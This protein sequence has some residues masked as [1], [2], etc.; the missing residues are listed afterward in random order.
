MA[1]IDDKYRKWIIAGFS[2]FLMV[3]FTLPGWFGGRLKNREDHSRITVYGK[4]KVYDSEIEDAK[5][6]VQFI[7]SIPYGI[8]L[9]QGMPQMSLGMSLFMGDPGQYQTY[10]DLYLALRVAQKGMSDLLAAPEVFALLKREAVHQGIRP[11]SDRV[12]SILHNQIPAE[13]IDEPRKLQDYRQKITA[14]V[15]VETLAQQS[16]G[17]VKV[18][19]PEIESSLA[20]QLQTLKIGVV[21]IDAKEYLSKVDAPTDE[22]VRAMFA[23]YGSRPTDDS[24]YR[25]NPFNF[26]YL[27]GDRVQFE[28]ITLPR[29]SL[30]RTAR[31]SKSEYDWEVEAQKYYFQNQKSFETDEIPSTQPASTQPTYKPFT[32][33][34]QSILDRLTDAKADQLAKMAQGKL[35]ATM[36]ADSRVYADAVSKKAP[37]P[38]SSLGPVYNTR[39]YLNALAAKVEA[40]FG[41]HAAVVSFTDRFLDSD[42]LARTDSIGRATIESANGREMTFAAY[43]LRYAKPFFETSGG[44]RDPGA[45]ALE[46]FQPTPAFTVPGPTG[47]VYV[48][49]V[50]DAKAS[51]VP[52]LAE[53]EAAVKKDAVTQGAQDLAVAAAEALSAEQPGTPLPTLGAAKGKK[54]LTLPALRRNT[55]LPLDFQLSPA[56]KSA[57]ITGCFNLLRIDP[58]NPRP[59]AVIS[60][61]R[62]R[63]VAVVELEGVEQL[64][65]NI[66]PARLQLQAFQ[67]T[68]AETELLF[69][70]QYFQKELVVARTDFKADAT[71]TG[72]L[73]AKTNTGATPAPAPAAP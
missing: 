62:D 49:R 15:L 43:V 19:K 53:V 48:G 38:A 6:E 57:F 25:T 55:E 69:L 1:L 40:E 67:Q 27:Q 42:Q 50:V 46:F 16:V 54:V 58:A 39:E 73:A 23:K 4:E 12:E 34:R 36:N 66:E 59:R 45:A 7:G 11:S 5:L 35:L 68:R 64:A 24:D 22:Q 28:Y 31:L 13:L 41:V 70:N 20:E 26:S 30:V 56:G 71:Y 72:A 21:V 32:Q 61:P 3:A 44:N 52:Q 47:G 8:Q 33:V 18:T 51:R 9:P 60:L 29:P 63:L 17:A 65:E 2:S 14:F 10:Q 37:P